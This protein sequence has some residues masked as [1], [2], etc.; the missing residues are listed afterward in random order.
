MVIEFE[1]WVASRPFGD[2]K[3][4]LVLGKGPTYARRDEFDLSKFVTISL[5]H[6]VTQQPVDIAHMIDFDVAED[7]AE[8]LATNARWLLMPRHPHLAFGRTRLSLEDL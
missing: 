1:Q 2:A 3:D 8:S 5:N 7:C 4:F 6:V